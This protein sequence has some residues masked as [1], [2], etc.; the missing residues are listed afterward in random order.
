ML[1]ANII[2]SPQ[3]YG[4][5][6][7]YV[8]ASVTMLTLGFIGCA[9]NITAIVLLSKATVFH[10]SFGYIC[11]SHL[12]ADSG[13][14]VVHIFWSG[15]ATILRLGT[16]VTA[17]LV[18]SCVGQITLLFW[19]ATLHSQVGIAINRLLAI[20]RPTLYNV[21][22]TRKG[23]AIFIS[24][25][26]IVSALQSLVHFWRIFQA[27]FCKLD[28][29]AERITG[30]C[31]YFY[32]VD[33]FSWTY[34]D[35]KCG[36]FASFYLDTIPSITSCVLIFV[37]HTAI[38]SC[39]RKKT[40]ILLRTSAVYST[41]QHL[42]LKKNIHFYVQGLLTALS[43]TSIVICFHL[44]SR[45]AASRWEKFAS[46]TLVWLVAHI[47]DGIIIIVFNKQLLA[48]VWGAFPRRRSKS[49]KT[50]AVH[51]AVD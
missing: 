25:F 27:L 41:E 21:I 3:D 30:G 10:T 9:I 32:D 26:W 1:P 45:F 28:T 42:M 43:L 5:Q 6:V 13:V 48:M 49:T 35:T 47:M 34:S 40:K 18:G 38:F 29:F 22:Y 36:R 33:Q 16:D 14:L 12:I 31:S 50:V 23:I 37:I 51:S 17:S 15:P 46:S 7:D 4:E 39:I 24:L 8:L 11:V 2:E 44:I 19:F 20:A